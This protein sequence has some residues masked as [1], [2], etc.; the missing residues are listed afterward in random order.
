MKAKKAMSII[1]SVF[2]LFSVF[3]IVSTSVR[4]EAIDNLTLFIISIAG[5]CLSLLALV[6]LGIVLLVR[7]I[8]EVIFNLRL[9][10]AD[11]DM[12]KLKPMQGM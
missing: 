12:D 5:I 1:G 6:V 7:K 2:L 8:G 9:L 4:F 10:K 3:L 11:N